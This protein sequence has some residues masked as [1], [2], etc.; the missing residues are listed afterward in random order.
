MTFP[1]GPTSDE[2]V[3]DHLKIDDAVDD[4]A[5][6]RVVAAVNQLVREL[7]IAASFDTEPAAADWS[8]GPR[9]IQGATMLAAR[10][11]ERRNSPNG[12]AA[13]GDGAAAYVQRN[14]PDVAILL[15]IGAYAKPQVG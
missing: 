5:I 1:D 11:F 10:L 12:V 14:D 9:I 4:A 7:P 8:A 3:K 13:F 2:L 6:A 15:R